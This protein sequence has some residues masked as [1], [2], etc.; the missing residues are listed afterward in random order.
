[1]WNFMAPKLS[2]AASNRGVEACST[3][4]VAEPVPKPVPRLDIQ[5]PRD[6]HRWDVNKSQGR[7]AAPAAKREVERT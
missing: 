5:C 2:Q 4:A 1:M 3:E 6:G 7:D